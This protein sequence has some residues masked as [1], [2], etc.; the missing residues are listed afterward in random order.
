MLC[1]VFH[2]FYVAHHFSCHT[3][4]FKKLLLCHAPFLSY[5]TITM[6]VL[7]S[8][9]RNMFYMQHCLY[10]ATCLGLTTCFI[11]F[12][13]ISIH[14][15]N[16]WARNII[17]MNKVPYWSDCCCAVSCAEEVLLLNRIARGKPHCLQSDYFF[18]TMKQTGVSAEYYSS[19]KWRSYGSCDMHLLWPS[20]FIGCVT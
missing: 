4:F 13:I 12:T 9:S 6:S 18:S 20:R 1:I 2:V 15:M 17:K 10:G 5:A 19:S 8:M 14:N 11:T 7:L 3:A 16:S